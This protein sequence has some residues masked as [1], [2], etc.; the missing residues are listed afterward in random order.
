MLTLIATQAETCTTNPEDDA[1]KMMVATEDYSNWYFWEKKRKILSLLSYG[2]SSSLPIR[3]NLL[4]SL[5][6]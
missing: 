3:P 5:I 1:T 4:P 6:Q 2:S